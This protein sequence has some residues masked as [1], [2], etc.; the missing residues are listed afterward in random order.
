MSLPLSPDV[1]S[2]I[3]SWIDRGRFPD[4][5]AVVAAA[6]QALDEREHAQ[7]LALRE[8]VRAGFESGDP[9]ELTPGL[10]DLLEREV[11]EAFLRGEQPDPEVC[12]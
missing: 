11:E 2:L 10:W 9:V 3:Q 12:P 7:F 6:L 4:A 5:A 1:E 8:K